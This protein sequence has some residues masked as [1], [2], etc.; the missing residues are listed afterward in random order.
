MWNIVC[1]PASFTVNSKVFDRGK[2]EGIERDKGWWNE[3]CWYVLS[4][5]G[6]LRKMVGKM[7]HQSM[8]W[9]C[10]FEGVSH[11]SRAWGYSSGTCTRQRTGHLQSPLIP[12]QPMIIYLSR[13]IL[14]PTSHFTIFYCLPS[15]LNL[16][17]IC[18]F[19]H[20]SHG[21][22]F[23]FFCILHSHGNHL[24]IFSSSSLHHTHTSSSSSY[25][26]S[27]PAPHWKVFDLSH[28]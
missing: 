17:H 27:G 8:I 21:R 13:G 16:L 12:S 4:I 7:W 22:A 25:Q 26:I 3:R 14:D 5:E 28:V 9:V 24:F 6:W 19:Y 15:A 20:T 10:L 11:K 2:I 23:S 1:I 18:T